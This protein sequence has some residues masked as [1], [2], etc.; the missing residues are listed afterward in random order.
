MTAL[1][2]IWSSP[3]VINSQYGNITI[4]WYTDMQNK[5]GTPTIRVYLYLDEVMN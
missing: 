4:R 3:F 1:M 2:N 5:R